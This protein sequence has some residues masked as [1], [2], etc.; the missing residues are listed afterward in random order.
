MFIYNVTLKIDHSI[1]EEWVKWMRE[2]HLP[3]VM[4]TGCFEKYQ[5]VKLLEVDE[6]EG[7]TYAAQ[8]F[9]IS[10]AQ[11]NR[12]IDMYAAKLRQDGMNKW[13]NKFIAFRTLM[14][15]IE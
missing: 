5:F 13:G 2:E 3:D 6:S 7:P 12:Y 9:A 1:H 10:K 11:Y 4:R 14:E 15:V 8:Y